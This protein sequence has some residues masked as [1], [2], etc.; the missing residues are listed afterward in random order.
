MS[1]ASSTVTSVWR[2]VDCLEI[3]Q[4]AVDGNSSGRVLST[5]EA[6]WVCNQRGRCWCHSGGCVVYIQTRTDGRSSVR[7]KITLC[8]RQLASSHSESKSA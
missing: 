3:R 6:S 5:A 4:W 7:D 1:R 2:H 8:S